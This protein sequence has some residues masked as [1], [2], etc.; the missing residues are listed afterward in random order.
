MKQL[1]YLFIATLAL[2][3]LNTASADS[4]GKLHPLLQWFDDKGQIVDVDWRTSARW[5]WKSTDN[6]ELEPAVELWI[7]LPQQIQ[8]TPDVADDSGVRI[9]EA[10]SQT[11]EMGLGQILVIEAQHRSVTAKLQVASGQQGLLVNLRPSSTR[12]LIHDSCLKYISSLKRASVS[13]V[14][15]PLFLGVNCTHEKSDLLVHIHASEGTVL[16]DNT[17]RISP[18]MVEKQPVFGFNLNDSPKAA[19]LLYAITFKEGP[20]A[21]TPAT[22]AKAETPV[23]EPTPEPHAT[24][25]TYSVVTSLA[26]S[27]LSYPRA[28]DTDPGFNAS[29]Y[30]IDFAARISPRENPNWEVEAKLPLFSIFPGPLHFPASG[31]YSLSGD[32][33]PLSWGEHSEFRLGAGW[34]ANEV[35][36]EQRSNASGYLMG[37][38]AKLAFNSE[39]C[40]LFGDRACEFRLAGEPLFGSA[41]SPFIHSLGVSGSLAFEISRS[42][43]VGHRLDLA[44]SFQYFGI[45]SDDGSSAGVTNTS[46]G[47]QVEL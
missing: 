10:P 13:A 42:F 12:I 40:G 21:E 30:N 2:L 46:L 28:P 7:A 6:G 32:Y 47:L 26:P 38:Q 33:L 14:P 35:H 20:K 22:S 17:I 23:A 43:F 29:A 44:L 11:H 24:P 16:P 41:R 15:G 19:P 5:M 45:E 36:L 25:S 37:P 34:D 8:V 9:M 31:V 4:G 3:Q 27:Y 18:G 1:Q 39:K